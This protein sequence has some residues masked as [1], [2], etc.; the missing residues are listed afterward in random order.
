MGNV[1]GASLCCVCHRDDDDD[2]DDRSVH[3]DQLPPQDVVSDVIQAAQ[4]SMRRQSY[5]IATPA[6]AAVSSKGRRKWLSPRRNLGGAGRKDVVDNNSSGQP[7]TEKSLPL[8]TVER[9]PPQGKVVTAKIAI[10]MEIVGP[11]IAPAS[12][13]FGAKISTDTEAQW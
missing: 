5:S 7:S 8:E 10:A 12:Q 6:A 13:P 1:T 3:D 2:D 11:K 4:D 9:P